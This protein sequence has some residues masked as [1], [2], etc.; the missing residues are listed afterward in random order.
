[1]HVWAALPHSRDVAVPRWR[2]VGPAVLT[3]LALVCTPALA[4][5]AEQA[6]EAL[7]GKEYAGV[8]RSRDPAS[9]LALAERFLTVATGEEVG[10]PLAALLCRRAHELSLLHP[11]GYRTAVHAMRLSEARHP[12]TRLACRDTLVDLER[13]RYRAARG[14]ARI[15]AGNDLIDALMAAAAA[16]RNAGRADEV[17]GLLSEADRTA[18]AVA[19]PRKAEIQLWRNRIAMCAES[20]ERIDELLKQVEAKP[21]DTAAHDELVRRLLVD[22]DDPVA[23]AEHLEGV[24]DAELRK[25]VPAAAKGIREAPELAASEMAQW[26]AG[27]MDEAPASAK[28][29]MFRRAWAYYEVY[30]DKHKGMDASHAE[31]VAGM[32]D[33]LA[34]LRKARLEELD[35][36]DRWLELLRLPGV[37]AKNGQLQVSGYKTST[38]LPCVIE[39][40]YQIVA[41]FSRG[42]EKRGDCGIH[43]PAGT[44]GA[45]F[46]MSGNGMDGY[47]SHVQQGAVKVPE[48]VGGREFTV[49][50]LVVPEGDCVEIL[51]D[52]NGKPY[53]HWSGP[54]RLLAHPHVPG[55]SRWRR[56]PASKRFQAVGM[57]HFLVVYTSMRVRSLAGQVRMPADGR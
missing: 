11:E 53:L 46:M 15:G 36:T 43:L 37:P 39:G 41:R 20:R 2:R 14:P 17:S 38:S 32:R 34:R 52:V 35:D 50:A 44:E 45:A 26:Y 10:P 18:S 5:E 33:L 13:R 51:V 30:L 24:A 42:T 47:I 25:Y 12:P 16:H 8:L 3:A 27:L 21:D 40:A 4:D 56:N 55:K 29:D 1:M 7:Y 9:V 6:F 57:G 19:R 54:Q 49:D 31:G 28:T 22:R 48:P 23:A